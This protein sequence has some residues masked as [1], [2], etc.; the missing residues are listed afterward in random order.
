MTFPQA[1]RE[2]T[3]STRCLH[4]SSHKSHFHSLPYYQL[5]HKHQTKDAAPR[6][7]YS[8]QSWLAESRLDYL[9]CLLEVQMMSLTISSL[10]YFLN[11]TSDAYNYCTLTRLTERQKSSHFLSLPNTAHF[12]KNVE[13]NWQVVKW[14]G[15]RNEDIVSRILQNGNDVSKRGLNEARIRSI[16]ENWSSCSPKS[17]HLW[18][19]SNQGKVPRKGATSSRRKILIGS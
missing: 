6:H 12:P 1:V 8:F 5:A 14:K 9:Q 15:G 13:T 19:W 4:R 17:C 7:L 18:V 11:L 3:R 16:Q 2:I 10:C